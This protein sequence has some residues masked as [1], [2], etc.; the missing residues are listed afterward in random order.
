[1]PLYD[2]RCDDCGDF[3]NWRPMSESGDSIPCPSCE[4]I[5]GR[6]VTAPSLALM[7][8]NNRIAHRRNE[9]SADQPDVVTRS[10]MGNSDAQGNQCSGGHGHHH[11][12]HGHSHGRPWM[13][14]H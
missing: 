3:R 11:A 4:L 5:V 6:A 2:Y 13:I 12:G 8:N 10:S 1:M 14:G 9:K 7:P